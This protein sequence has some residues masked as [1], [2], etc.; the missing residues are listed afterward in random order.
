MDK[1]TIHRALCELKLIDAKIEKAIAQ[2][3]PSGIYQKGRRINGSIPEEDFKTL[4]QSTYDSAIALM[5]RKTVIK[6]AIVQSNGKT[7]VKIGERTMTVADAITAKAIIKFKKAFIANLTSRH[8]AQVAAL[9][10]NNSMVMQNAQKLLEGAMGKDNTK[11]TKEDVEAILKPFMDNNEFHLFDP[12][13]I[14]EKIKVLEKEVGDF[15]A[16]VDAVLSESNAVTFI[17]F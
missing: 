3:N 13:K 9:N 7:T 11:V 8:R 12:L 15:E 17:E 14:E 5:A 6:S 4:A 2:V 1:M 16:D 10:T